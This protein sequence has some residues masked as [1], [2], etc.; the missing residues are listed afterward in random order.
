MKTKFVFAAA[1]AALALSVSANAQTNL[2]V[3][4]DAGRGYATTTFEMF[5]GDNWGNTFF[6]IDHY[7]T[8]ADQ[9]ETGA[10]G[11]QNGTY[12]EIERCINFWQGSKLGNLSLEVEYDGGSF[13]TGVFCFGANYFMHSADFKNTFNVALLYTQNCGFDQA[14]TP[15]KLSGVWGMQDIFGVAGLRFSGFIDVWGI[16]RNWDKDGNLFLGGAAL[17]AKSTK[18]S[19]LTEPQL[20]YNIGKLINCENLNVGGEVELSYNFSGAAQGFVCNPAVGVKWVF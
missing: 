19:V 6:F 10:R 17:A 18:M 2:Q 3:F 7:Y 12:Y 16:D 5:K 14:T 4:Y 1:V 13:G 15:V 11:N 8:T 20:W 9:R